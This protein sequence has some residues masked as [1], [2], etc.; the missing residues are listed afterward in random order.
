MLKLLL[1]LLQVFKLKKKYKKKKNNKLLLEK[2]A[3]SCL[4]VV[5]S[6]FIFYK[7][8]M[9]QELTEATEAVIYPESKTII[10]KFCPIFDYDSVPGM[11]HISNRISL[12]QYFK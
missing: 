1:K 6:F 4:I 2:Y 10:R 5:G 3:F 7:I 11:F 12:F 8:F 9:T